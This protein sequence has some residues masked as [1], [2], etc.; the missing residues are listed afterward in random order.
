MD[1]INNAHICTLPVLEANVHD[2]PQHACIT[3]LLIP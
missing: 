1:Q 2:V 3:G